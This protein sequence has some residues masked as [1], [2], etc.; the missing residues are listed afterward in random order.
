MLREL[1]E[2]APLEGVLLVPKQALPQAGADSPATVFALAD[3]HRAERRP[4]TVGLQDGRFVEILAGLSEGEL[5][6]TSGL[7]DLTDGEQVIADVV[8]NPVALAR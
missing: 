5:V 2:F 7:T 1:F 6:A 4:I 3:S 8:D